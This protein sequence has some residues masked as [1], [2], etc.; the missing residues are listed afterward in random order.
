MYLSTRP[1]AGKFVKFVNV[2]TY[3]LGVV[4]VCHAHQP[5][6]YITLRLYCTP[7]LHGVF[8]KR[9][10]PHDAQLAPVLGSLRNANT[11][12]KHLMSPRCAHTTAHWCGPC[13]QIRQPNGC[14]IWYRIE[15]A[16]YAVEARKPTRSPPRIPMRLQLGE[17]EVGRRARDARRPLGAQWGPSECVYKPAI[18]SKRGRRAGETKTVVMSMMTATESLLSARARSR[19]CRRLREQ[20]C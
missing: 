20:E 1:K 6:L 16:R 2:A 10:L 12:R 11:R 3:V 5:L 15:R 8:S 13:Y 17:R 14:L 9:L 18:R 7:F 4:F 19:R